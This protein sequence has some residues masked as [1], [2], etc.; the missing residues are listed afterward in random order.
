MY[1]CEV[2][3]CRGHRDVHVAANHLRGARKREQVQRACV[4]RIAQRAA[5]AMPTLESGLV[6][7][8]AVGRAATADEA[9]E[10]AARARQIVSEKGTRA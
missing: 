7:L 2:R 6:V 8:T 3:G 9:R 10:R 4:A 5:A 1:A